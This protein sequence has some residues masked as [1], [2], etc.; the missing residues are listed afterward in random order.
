MKNLQKPHKIDRIK[1]SRRDANFLP[2]PSISGMM[3]KTMVNH[4]KFATALEIYFWTSKH[5]K[6]H[7]IDENWE[8]SHSLTTLFVGFWALE[9][10]F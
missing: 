8:K 7:K 10:Y 5:G 6:T 1:M 2:L 3:S 4:Q 9:S